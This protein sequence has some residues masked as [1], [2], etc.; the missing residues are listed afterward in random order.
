[1]DNIVKAT[2]VFVAVF[3]LSILIERFL[4]ILKSIYDLLDSR[5]DWYRFWTRRAEALQVR[6]YKRIRIQQYMGMDSLNRVLASFSN[7]MLGKEDNYTSMVP[8]ISGDLMRALYVKI[9]ATLIGIGCGI[10]MALYFQINIV[11]LIMEYF[12]D[13]PKP[14]QESSII[15]TIVT[16]IMLGLGSGPVHKLITA[17]ERKRDASGKG[18]AL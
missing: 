16:G 6:L 11:L 10:L 13:I 7:L 1:M 8:T 5:L 17:I 14:F 4:E 18:A 15:Y 12:P 2:V 3:S 9:G